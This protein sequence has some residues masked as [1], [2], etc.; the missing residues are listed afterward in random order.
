MVLEYLEGR[1]LDAELQS[2]G[3]FSIDQAVDVVQQVA[4]AMAEAHEQGIVH[5][6]LKP[7]NLFVCRAGD[8]R[9]VK[10]LDFGISRDEN[11]SSRITAVD[12][13]SGHRRTPPPSS[14]VMP[15]RPTRGPTSGRSA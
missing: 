1:D 7:A 14:S 2:V 10:I 9:V 6:D 12:S 4:D 11:E 13:S 15:R 5:R 8:R 3:R